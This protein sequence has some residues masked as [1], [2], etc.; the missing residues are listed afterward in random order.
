MSSVSICHLGVALVREFY[1]NLV[2]RKETLC[3]VRGKWISFHRED[4]NQMLRMGKL[5][6]GAK[7]IKLKDDPNYQKILEV[8]I[9]G[10]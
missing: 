2:D 9:D 1:A 5:S 3:Y 7:F 4:I 10:K 6:D 8:L